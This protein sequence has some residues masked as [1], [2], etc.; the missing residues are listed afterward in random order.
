MAARGLDIPNVDLV[1]HYDV[2][3]DNE[4]FL[5]RS[6]R[7]GRAGKT[8]TAVVLFTDRESRALGLILRATKVGGRWGWAMGRGRWARSGWRVQGAGEGCAWSR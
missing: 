1:V 3:Q 2:P 6:G 7:T 4:A 5:H 8:G